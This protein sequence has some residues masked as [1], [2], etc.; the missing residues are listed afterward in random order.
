MSANLCVR[1]TSEGKMIV[2]KFERCKH[3]QD[4]L[5]ID[6][7]WYRSLPSIGYRGAGD[8][9]PFHHTLSCLDRSSCIFATRSQDLANLSSMTGRTIDNPKDFFLYDGHFGFGSD[10]VR[11]VNLQPSRSSTASV[12]RLTGEAGFVINL[13]QSIIDG[14]ASTPSPSY[15]HALHLRWPDQTRKKRATLA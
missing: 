4:D 2:R 14:I 3:C 1:I 13:S 12:T 10:D 9:K 11:R 5:P 15:G 6:A 7:G 8:S